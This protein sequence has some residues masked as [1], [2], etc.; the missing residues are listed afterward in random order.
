MT[1]VMEE[2]WH[3]VKGRSMEPALVEGDEVRLAPL[4]ALPGEGEVVVTRGAAGGLLLHR[5]VAA[6]RFAIVTRGD[7]CGSDDRAVPVGHVLLRAVEM[8]RAGRTAAIP[9]APGALHR[10]RARVARA[11]AALRWGRAIG[12]APRAGGAA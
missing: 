2:L 4:R 12:S 1:D 5:V 7:A 10:L 6:S 11:R 8:R 3:K 9:S